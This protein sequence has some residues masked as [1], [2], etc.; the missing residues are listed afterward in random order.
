MFGLKLVKQQ[1]QKLVKRPIKGAR[2]GV[3]FIKCQ[4][5]RQKVRTQQGTSLQP[6]FKRLKTNSN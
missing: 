4:A 2:K 1:Q 6:V 5:L 3:I